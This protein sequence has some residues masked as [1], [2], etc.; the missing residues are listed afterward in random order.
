MF[1]MCM[2]FMDSL[3]IVQPLYIDV[4]TVELYTLL[5]P[6]LS[7]SAALLSARSVGFTAGTSHRTQR[8]RFK[9]VHT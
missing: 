2:V 9:P 8:E 3:N 1:S 4:T 6:P 7:L 5:P